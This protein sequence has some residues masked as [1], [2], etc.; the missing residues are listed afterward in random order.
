MSSVALATPNARIYDSALSPDGRCLALAQSP[1][2]VILSTLTGRI[3]STVPQSAPRCLAF[4]P[5]G[6]L[7]VTGDFDQ[8]T[9]IWDIESR[10][11][12]W[13]V[14]GFGDTVSAVAFSSNGLLAA[15]SWDGSI[16]ICDISAKRV[17]TTLTGHKSCIEELAFVHDGRTLASGSDDGTLK[18]WNLLTGREVMS[19]KTPAN[20][21]FVTFS[22]DDTILAAGGMSDGAIHLW[23][24]PSCQQIATAGQLNK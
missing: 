5:D 3:A 24:A 4:S 23:R 6:K 10:R 13:T 14:A 18:L 19:F 12:V 9:R 22:P 15:G 1:Q 17:L 2:V 7:M 8:T 16:K 20:D 11:L 21:Y